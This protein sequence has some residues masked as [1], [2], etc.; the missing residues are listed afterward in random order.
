MSLLPTH[1]WLWGVRLTQLAAALALCAPALAQLP[2]GAQQAIDARECEIECKQSKPSGYP[3]TSWCWWHAC[4][5]AQVMTRE[6]VTG[7]RARRS[8]SEQA[9]GAE[10]FSVEAVRTPLNYSALPHGNPC[11]SA[12]PACTPDCDV[13][14][15]QMQ[16]YSERV[17]G[18]GD[19]VIDQCD[20]DAIK[21][22]W[23]ELQAA[24]GTP[25]F[26][27]TQ[28][29]TF[30][31]NYYQPLV[32]FEREYRAMLAR[33]PGELARGAAALKQ[34]GSYRIEFSALEQ[35]LLERCAPEQHVKV[36]RLNSDVRER[37][38][39]WQAAE[40][41]TQQRIESSLKALDICMTAAVAVDNLAEVERCDPALAQSV[42]DVNQR[43]DALG[44]ALT[45]AQ[46][47]LGEA[48]QDLAACRNLSSQRDALKRLLGVTIL[49]QHRCPALDDA[50]R[51][52]RRVGAMLQAFDD[53]TRA[54]RELL[55]SAEINYRY[56]EWEEHVRKMNEARTRRLGDPACWQSAPY[57]E[58]TKQVDDAQQRAAERAD[59]AR[60]HMHNLEVRMQSLRPHL[61][62][63]SSPDPCIPGVQENLAQNLPKLEQALAAAQSASVADCMLEQI[64]QAHA[65]LNAARQLQARCA[66]PAVTQRFDSPVFGGNR[67]DWCLRW[68]TD[69]GN[70]AADA[71]CRSKN[72][73]WRALKWEQDVDIGQ[74]SPTKIIETG[75]ICDQQFCDGFKYIECGSVQ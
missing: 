4:E 59:L 58:L 17:R 50:R 10:S 14:V 44:K 47:V 32:P 30:Y 51:L 12:H 62:G 73:S 3:C 74:R 60:M 31:D 28:L 20:I 9:E 71:F 24:A 66:Q 70:G 49:V 35:R 11:G 2:E 36:K 40:A 69:C 45:A 57:N 26:D 63:R 19:V 38:D 15:R 64:K 21:R 34:C 67:L 75:Q 46:A 37:A 41:L 16:R 7:G 27:A 52:E 43:V 13:Y 56:C 55:E 48:E 65:T 18:G 61:E 22:R 72:P 29:R 68:G 42:R 23:A 5:K 25:G 53:D 6:I 54:V 1:R 39:A 8:P 33:L